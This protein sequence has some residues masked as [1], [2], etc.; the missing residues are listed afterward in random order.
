MALRVHPIT[1]EI[2]RSITF[3]PVPADYSIL[4]LHTLP[5]TGGDTLWGSGYD[6]YDKL[7]PTWQ[8]FAD[9]LTA[10][11]A[12]PGFLKS[13]NDHGFKLHTA[14]RGSPENVGE[15]LEAVHP[16]FHTLTMLITG[17]S[18]QSSYRVEI[19]FRSWSSCWTYQ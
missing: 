13:A 19:C 12:Q 7:S 3:E 11:Y 15:I 5:P 6:L 1:S 8:R 4:T 16:V 10:T 9:G 2:D 14:P 18:Y 17:G